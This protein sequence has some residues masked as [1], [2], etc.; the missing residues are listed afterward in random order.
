MS[1]LAIL[2]NVVHHIWRVI[3]PVVLEFVLQEYK[4]EILWN[5]LTLF[6]WHECLEVIEL[7]VCLLPFLWAVS[8]YHIFVLEQVNLLGTIS[9]L[10]L[11]RRSIWS[12]IF[13]LARCRPCFFSPEC[14]LYVPR[15]SRLYKSKWL[16]QEF[17]V[18][19]QVTDLISI[20]LLTALKK[21]YYWAI[22]ERKEL[23]YMLT[24]MGR[25]GNNW[26]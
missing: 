15:S 26:T 5:I 17:T 20:P 24:D 9:E 6:L 7:F 19:D 22:Q 8:L 12:F 23:C 18:K 1:W 4:R 14:I 3:F 11:S 2:A 16:L 13:Y 25:R 10:L 21:I